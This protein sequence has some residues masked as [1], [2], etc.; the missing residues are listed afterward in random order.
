MGDDAAAKGFEYMQGYTYPARNSTNAIISYLFSP[1]TLVNGAASKGLT[2]H[3]IT[4][5]TATTTNIGLDFDLFKS[6]IF[7]QLDIFQRK[8]G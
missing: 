2:N 7:G 4:W 6:K 1:S 3:N 8:R 5:Y